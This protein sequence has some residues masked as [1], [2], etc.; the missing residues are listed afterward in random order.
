ME[1]LSDYGTPTDSQS[2]K[3]NLKH[4][5]LLSI[6][7]VT[8]IACGSM[9]NKTLWTSSF[10]HTIRPR[11]IQQKEEKSLNDRLSRIATRN[12]FSWTL[13]IDGIRTEEKPLWKHDWLED[14]I[15][16]DLSV[17]SSESSSSATE[18]EAKHQTTEYI[19]KWLEDA[20]IRSQPVYH[21]QIRQHTLD[22]ATEIRRVVEVAI[23]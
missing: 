12:L 2:L 5:S 6:W 23:P 7:I 4:I 9:F 17:E 11:A 20:C 10:T 22:G 13:F 16:R 14:L 8:G 1:T 15:E 19:E 3:K 18:G 21:S